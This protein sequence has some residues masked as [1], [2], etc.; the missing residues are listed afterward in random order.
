MG[1]LSR[2]LPSMA[3]R[4]NR[5]LPR[6]AIFRFL[7]ELE[8]GEPT[9]GEV[10]SVR[11]I[12]RMVLYDAVHSR[13]RVTMV[14]GTECHKLWVDTSLIEPFTTRMG[15]LYLFL[16]EIERLTDEECP[17]LKARVVQ[18]VDGVDLPALEQALKDQRRY[19]ATREGSEMS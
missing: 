2:A 3:T 17:L 19:L 18:C 14:N 1:R 15:G 11:T 7:W 13:A 10:Q 16:G 8:G 5:A 4:F 6:P 12:G 9:D